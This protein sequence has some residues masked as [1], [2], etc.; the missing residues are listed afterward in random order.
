M[1]VEMTDEQIRTM[2]IDP[3]ER[4]KGFELM[5]HLYKELV[6]F[7]AR[8][9]VVSHDDADDIT[10][11][12]FIKAWKALEGYRGDSKVSTWLY[13]ITT[14]ESITFIQRSRKIAGIPL[15]DVAYKLSD[16][17][18]EDPYFSGDEIERKLQIAIALL[19]DKQR[20][21]FLMRYYN[22]MAYQEMSEITGTSVGALKA[23]YHHAV[24][25]IELFLC[26][27]D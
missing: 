8:R 23:S 15:E 11:N 21:V 24:K 7:H 27:N 25:K 18:C 16:R 9:M 19:P 14:N 13:R 5:V 20:A 6:Y 1:L 12:V 26:S 3:S 2:L 17:L 4:K 22:E 10:Q